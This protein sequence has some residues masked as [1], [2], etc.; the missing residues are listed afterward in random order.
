M[1]GHRFWVA[2]PSWRDRPGQAKQQTQLQRG[3]PAKVVRFTGADSLNLDTCP[4]AW[5]GTAIGVNYLGAG[6]TR[7]EF[8]E[9][10]LHLGDKV[11]NQLAKLIA[12]GEYGE[13]SRLPSEIELTKKFQVSRP[14]LRQAL[15]RL[16]A[17]RLIVSRRGAGSFV[18]R[19]ESSD[20]LKFG[21]LQNIRDVRKCLEFRCGLESEA[22]SRAA[23][24][25]SETHCLQISRAI[26]TMQQAISQGSQGVEEDFAFHLAIAQAT[27]NR[28]FVISLEA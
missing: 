27:E 17:E 15:A 7:D 23:S 10:P 5:R 6:M 8:G 12:S 3:Q 1:F 18:Q 21:Q 4:Q 25:H 9:V 22:A 2:P 13:N 16:R 14:I 11:Y 20:V 24:R 19:R 26:K 28:F